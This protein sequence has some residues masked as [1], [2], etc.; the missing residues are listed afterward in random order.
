MLSEKVRLRDGKRNK[1]APLSDL[2][3]LEDQVC[4]APFVD[5]A[6]FSLFAVSDLNISGS[7]LS[8]EVSVKWNAHEWYDDSSHARIPPDPLVIQPRNV[9]EHADIQEAS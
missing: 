2:S 3:C 7:I 1:I 8:R 6:E 4:S 9:S 5:G